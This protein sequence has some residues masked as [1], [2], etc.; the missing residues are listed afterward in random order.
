VKHPDPRGA[1]EA[2][3]AL[4]R[5]WAP[6]TD[7]IAPGD[8]ARFESR[9]VDDALRLAPLVDSLPDG[10]AV[11]VGSGVGIPGVPLAIVCPGR[12]WRLL[13]PR[14][15]RAAFLDEVVRELG[16]NCEVLTVTAEQAATRPDLSGSHVVA[17]A[18]ALAPPA[19][20]FELL[21]PLIRSD[22]VAAVMIGDGASL[23]PETREWARG[24]ATMRPRAG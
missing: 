7:L 20:A 24:I 8:L 4:V 18:R 1:L 6:T 22:G 17:V 21:L 23:P 2:Y 13:E 11:D 12:L 3:A 15:K 9:H 16:L 10:P 5:K 19:R 14:R